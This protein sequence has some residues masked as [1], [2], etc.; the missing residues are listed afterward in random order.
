MDKPSGIKWLFLDL[1]SYFASVEQQER[2]E[3]R[4][5]PVAVVPAA[6]NSTCAIAASYEAK[7]YGIKTG[8]KIYDARRMSPDLHCILGRH[9]TYVTYH[10]KVIEEVV[11]H[12]PIH[13]IRS[14]DELDSCLPPNKRD[15]ERAKRVAMNI[16]H[17]IWDHVGPAIS[18]SIGLAPNSLL[19]KIATNTQKPDGLVIIRQEDL[20]GPLLSLK[21]TDIPGVRYCSKHIFRAIMSM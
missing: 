16:K 3:L 11:K 2:P 19:A 5:K 12:T 4:G 9:E 10:H 18:C 8:T 1:N 15:I 14:I 20:P 17:G 13:K 7:A 21:L 6:T